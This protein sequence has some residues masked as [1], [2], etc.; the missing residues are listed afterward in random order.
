LNGNEKTHVYRQEYRIN[1]IKKRKIETMV[2]GKITGMIILTACRVPNT[3]KT[4]NN[5]NYTD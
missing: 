1:R 3:R 5:N 2:H 4:M